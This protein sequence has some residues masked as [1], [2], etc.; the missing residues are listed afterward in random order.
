M[1]LIYSAQQPGVTSS[2]LLQ[3]PY[4]HPKSLCFIQGGSVL[5][6]L[7]RIRVRYPDQDQVS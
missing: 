4:H 5:K 7:I 2:I 3:V 6:Q 1:I